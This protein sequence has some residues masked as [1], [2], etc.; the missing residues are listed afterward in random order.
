MKK[1]TTKIIAAVMAVLMLAALAG[2]GLLESEPVKYDIGNGL[3][4]TLPAGMQEVELEGFTKILANDKIGVYFVRETVDEL[5]DVG[6]ENL[7]L[8]EYA[9]LSEAAYALEN[10]YTADANGNLV[11]TYNTDV[12]GVSYFYYT[13]L[14]QA[15]DAFW[16][17]N[18][19]CEDSAKAL[20]S[21]LF[22]QWNAGIVME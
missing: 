11:T 8:E 3:S 15:A 19:V 20:Y 12:D 4:V 13:T 7:T 9:E 2:C 22:T 14:R 1:I 16:T 21:D 10:P 6:L 18:F 17:I 5:A